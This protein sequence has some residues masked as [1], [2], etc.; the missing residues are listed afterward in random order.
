MYNNFSLDH[1]LVYFQPLFWT[2]APNDVYLCVA[3][4]TDK[5]GPSVKS[6]TSLWFSEIFLYCENCLSAAESFIVHV[7]VCERERKWKMETSEVMIC[8]KL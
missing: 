8:F 7:C 5:Y 2:A 1:R 3:S 6:W 4:E